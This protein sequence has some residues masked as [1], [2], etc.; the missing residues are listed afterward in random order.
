MIYQATYTL[1]IDSTIQQRSETA[2]ADVAKGILAEDPATPNHTQRL[3]WAKYCLGSPATVMQ[4]SL[5]YIVTDPTVNAAGTA[6][7]DADLKNA[8]TN[9]LPYI[10]GN[11]PSGSAA[12]GATAPMVAPMVRSYPASPLPTPSL[13]TVP[14]APT[15][16]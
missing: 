10:L 6:C 3:S 2:C 5:W 15:G 14:A 9:A 4:Q 8:V 11:A 13:P 16:N 1:S 12:L 7:L